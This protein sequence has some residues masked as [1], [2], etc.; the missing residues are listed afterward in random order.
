M[1]SSKKIFIC[2]STAYFMRIVVVIAV[3]CQRQTH[4]HTHTRKS[5]HHAICA[6]CKL[7]SHFVCMCVCA[8]LVCLQKKLFLQ[9]YLYELWFFRV[10]KMRMLSFVLHADSNIVRVKLWKKKRQASHKIWQQPKKNIFHLIFVR[11]QSSFLNVYMKFKMRNKKKTR[12]GQTDF[13]VENILW[14][15]Y[16]THNYPTKNFMNAIIK[17]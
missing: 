4:T 10:C 16:Y 11:F 9:L 6:I 1:E 7:A 17:L 15:A 2:I 8:R 3:A 5:F 14:F 13:H 12:N